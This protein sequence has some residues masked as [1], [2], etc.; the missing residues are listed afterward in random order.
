[1]S[2]DHAIAL[3]AA[4]RH[5][6]PLLIAFGLTATFM[7][8]EV[9]VGL[10]A[11]SVALLSDALHM[12]TDVLGLGMA[13]A[14]VRL[15]MRPAPAHRTY[16]SYRAEVLA[17]LLNGVLLFAV[18]GYVL[19]EAVQRLRHPESVA[20]AAMLV[21]AAAGLV[22]NLVSWRL[23][24]AGSRESLNVKGAS[25]EVLSDLLGSIGVLV[26]GLVVAITGWTYADPI[27]G[28]GIG[29][30]ILPRTWRLTRQAVRVLLESAPA[31]IDVAE[32]R[33]AVAEL[34]SVDDVHDLHVWTL[35]SGMEA[36]SVHV[37]AAAGVAV[38]QVI[39]DVQRVLADRFDVAHATVQAEPADF[40]HPPPPV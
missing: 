12:G 26:A 37:V 8:V 19:Y 35:T 36:A 7:V 10:A 18:A 14:A 30:F 2:G 31:H 32:V 39:V 17:A 15:A 38:E 11:R 27:I 9:I 1:M 34:P 6:R 5:R 20:S 23:L 3:S 22:V 40:Q 16:G 28:A 4:G 25:F 13:L 24:A 33:S 21:V 29:L